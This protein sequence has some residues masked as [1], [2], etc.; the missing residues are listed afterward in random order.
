[1]I[2]RVGIVFRFAVNR[3]LSIG[4]GGDDTLWM[5]LKRQYAIAGLDEGKS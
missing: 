4:C 1:M 3:A 2:G 5:R